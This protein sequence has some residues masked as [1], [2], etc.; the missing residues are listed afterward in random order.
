VHP[1]PERAARIAPAATMATVHPPPER[2]ARTAPAATMATVHPPPERAAR[3][4]PVAPT[5]T[6][7][8]PPERAARIA[9]VAP[10]ATV[11]PP[12]ER[13][14]NPQQVDIQ[15]IMNMTSMCEETFELVDTHPDKFHLESCW[16]KAHHHKRA[17]SVPGIRQAS[18]QEC[19]TEAMNLCQL[20][21]PAV[22]TFIIRSVS[23]EAR[24]LFVRF[25]L[26][27]SLS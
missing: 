4:A 24:K 6:V 13:A 20:F 8:P 17:P 21:Q 27:Y 3:T 7:D 23:R 15:H 11:D 18:T 16:M 2:A 19:N 14:A 22:H 1:P 25:I 5:A 9:L 26:I 10:T 12:L